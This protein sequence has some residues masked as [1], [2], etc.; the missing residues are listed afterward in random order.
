MCFCSLNNEFEIMLR[1]GARS[2]VST[3][4]TNNFEKQ[5]IFS[6]I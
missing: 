6:K 1:E 4:N 3:N 5:E 2:P